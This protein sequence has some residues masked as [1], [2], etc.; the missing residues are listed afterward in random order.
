[1]G[2]RSPTTL[3]PC[4]LEFFWDDHAGCLRSS[5]VLS[6][7][8][9]WVGGPDLGKSRILPEKLTHAR[10]PS[11]TDLLSDPARVLRTRERWPIHLCV[12]EFLRQGTESWAQ[13]QAFK[14]DNLNDYRWASMHPLPIGRQAL[15]ENREVDSPSEWGEVLDVLPFGGCETAMWAVRVEDQGSTLDLFGLADYPTASH[16]QLDVPVAGEL[17][18]VLRGQGRSPIDLLDAAVRWWAQFRGLTFRGRPKGTG[19]WSS[20]EHFEINLDQVLAEMRSQGEKVTQENVSARLNIHK[21]T[22]ARWLQACGRSWQET[23]SG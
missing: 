9:E 2:L 18:C 6:L 16:K 10:T 8:I 23:R 12:M 19:T 14:A 20:P 4:L 5:T 1:M 21:Q 15:M 3:I 13:T 22:L 17:A 11:C 7:G